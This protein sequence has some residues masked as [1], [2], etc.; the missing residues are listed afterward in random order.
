MANV[1][2]SPIMSWNPNAVEPQ[3]RLPAPSFTIKLAASTTYPMGALLGEV[4]ATPGTFGLYV[5]SG[6]GGLGNWKAVLPRACVTDAAGNIYEAGQASEE[7]PGVSHLSVPAWFGGCF[8]QADLVTLDANAV[9]DGPAN[10]K[11]L[12][13]TVAGANALIQF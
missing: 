4:T 9:T 8:K 12:R 3:L 1:F 6:S 2:D 10:L 11:V 13:G 7:L 5:H